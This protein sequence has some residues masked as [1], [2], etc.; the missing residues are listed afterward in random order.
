VIG[1]EFKIESFVEQCLHL[2]LGRCSRRQLGIHQQAQP[3]TFGQSF[4][5]PRLLR[6]RC[7]CARRLRTVGDSGALLQQCR[8]QLLESLSPG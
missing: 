8:S 1:A 5:V 6:R 7:G 3:L 4:Y 2:L